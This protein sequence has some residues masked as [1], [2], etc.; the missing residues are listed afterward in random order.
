[1]I[2]LKNLFKRKNFVYLDL[3]QIKIFVC[4]KYL[5]ISFKLELKIGGFLKNFKIN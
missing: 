2:L 1:M 5:I 4:I 3:Q